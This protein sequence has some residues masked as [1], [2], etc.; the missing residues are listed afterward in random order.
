MLSRR[1][2][3]FDPDKMVKNFIEQT[4]DSL[5]L[6]F[7]LVVVLPALLLLGLLVGCTF[8]VPAFGVAFDLGYFGYSVYWLVRHVPFDGWSHHATFLFIGLFIEPVALIV[9]LH[10]CR[11]GSRLWDLYDEKFWSK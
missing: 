7:G 10:L 1:K 2:W 9:L 11:L 6:L 3:K 8:V 4:K 5:D